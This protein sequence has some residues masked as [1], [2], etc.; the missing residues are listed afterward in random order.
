LQDT[1]D[2]RSKNWVKYAIALV[3]IALVATPITLLAWYA[4]E[5]TQN[6]Q[7]KPQNTQTTAQSPD[8][9]L[10]A[11]GTFPAGMRLA[12]LPLITLTGPVYTDKNLS[13]ANVPCGVFEDGNPMVYLN[14]SGTRYYLLQYYLFDGGGYLSNLNLTQA[15]Q[16]PGP[17]G[18]GYWGDFNVTGCVLQN[19]F[20]VLKQGSSTVTYIFLSYVEVASIEFLKP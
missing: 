20:P 15:T 10:L 18:S 3:L 7:S 13:F 2:K 17:T 6:P 9:T 12:S 11:D 14:A 1:Q 16:N 8:G 5:R 4:L 19:W